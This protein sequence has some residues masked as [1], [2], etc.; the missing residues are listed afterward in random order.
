MSRD[1][2]PFCSLQFLTFS[3]P[4]NAKAPLGYKSQ[5]LLYRQNAIRPTHNDE[6]LKSALLARS[7]GTRADAVQQRRGGTRVLPRILRPDRY[8]LVLRL[9]WLDQG[10]TG[11]NK[12]S[13]G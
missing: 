9:L 8:M 13:D 3:L 7:C 2:Q 12:R 1:L 10:H 4:E 5:P 6:W 11:E